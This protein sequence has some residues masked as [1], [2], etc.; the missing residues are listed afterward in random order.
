MAMMENLTKRLF[1]SFIQSQIQNAKQQAY[2]EAYRYAREQDKGWRPVY[3]SSGDKDLLSTDYED[4]HKAAYKLYTSNPTAKALVDLLTYFVLSE[5]LTISATEDEVDQ[6][7]QK[8]WNDEQNSMDLRIFRLFAELSIFGEQFPV[9]FPNLQTG[10]LEIIQK[11]PIQVE[12]IATDPDNYEKEIGLILKSGIA[13]GKKKMIVCYRAINQKNN[14]TRMSAFAG[15]KELTPDILAEQ[16]PKEFMVGTATVKRNDFEIQANA[17]ALHYKVNA[18]TGSLRGWSDLATNLDWLSIYDEGLKNIMRLRRFRSA[19]VYDVT[20]NG[21]TPQEIQ[22]RDETIRENPPRPGSVNLHNDKETW[23]ALAPNIDSQN[24][25]EDLKQV[26]RHIGR[27]LMLPEHYLGEG[28]DANRATAAEMGL[29]TLKFMKGRQ[30]FFKRLL[31]DL[32]NLAIDTDMASAN[33]I[34][35]AKPKID[36][37]FKMDFPDIDQRDNL[38]T[39]QAINQIVAGLTI[40]R[41][42]KWLTDKTC[43]RLLIK[44]TGEDI[45]QQAEEDELAATAKKKANPPKEDEDDDIEVPPDY[46]DSQIDSFVKALTS[47][48]E[49]WTA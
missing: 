15:M 45:D 24:S 13:Q 37:T 10:R 12:A 33:G 34:L 18:V 43:S 40:A 35:A 41:D 21:A 17:L 5:E 2:D 38:Q 42:N 4:L 9:V 8:F 26:L 29:P 23:T 19:F 36:R 14:A 28:G 47:Q 6:V 20:L 22:A 31:A 46:Q 27:A 16:L 39:A 32:I 1:G 30:M 11:D 48:D 7:I 3:A 25:A 44:W 49:D